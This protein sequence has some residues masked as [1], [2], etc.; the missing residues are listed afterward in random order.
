MRSRYPWHV[1]HV[2]KKIERLSDKETMLQTAN[3]IDFRERCMCWQA[4]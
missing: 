1:E 3:K 4:P 2:G